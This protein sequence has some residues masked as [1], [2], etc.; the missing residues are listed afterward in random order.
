MT[1]A[2]EG[3]FFLDV[4]NMLLDNYCIVADLNAHLEGGFGSKNRDRYW[5]AFEALRTEEL[6]FDPR[7]LPCPPAK[8]TVQRIGDLTVSICPHYSVL[9]KPHVHNRRNHEVHTTTA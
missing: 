5:T 2:D 7:Q 4:D 1:S 8:P 3:F 9:S 6:T